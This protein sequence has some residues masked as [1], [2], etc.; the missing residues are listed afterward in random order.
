MYFGSSHWGSQHWAARHWREVVEA[1]PEV[2]APREGGGGLLK[3]RYGRLTSLGAWEPDEEEKQ[4]ARRLTRYLDKPPKVFADRPKS[5]KA[6]KKLFSDK[7]N[8]AKKSFLVDTLTIG[9]TKRKSFHASVSA[10]EKSEE[11]KKIFQR[12]QE[13]EALLLLLIAASA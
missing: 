5:L 4:E 8:S 10:L 6:S 11:F 12:R 9:E 7:L 3:R 13:E 2:K 1:A